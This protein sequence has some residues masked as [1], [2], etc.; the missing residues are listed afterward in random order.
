M[1]KKIEI[2]YVSSLCSTK[3]YYELF[4]ELKAKLGL[5][6]QKYHRLLAMG[7]VKNNIEVV[8]VSAIPIIRKLTDKLYYRKSSEVTDN[9]NYIYLPFVSL[10]ILRH[11]FL[12]ISCFITIVKI[13]HNNKNNVVILCDA[14]DISISMGGLLA[15]KIMH[16]RSICIVTDAPAFLVNNSK[17]K[18][19]LIKKIEFKLIAILNTLIINKFNAY[20]FLTNQMN[21]LINNREKPYIVLEG[22]VDI[23]MEDVINDI[24]KKYDK[25]ICMYAGS[26]KKVYGIKMLTEAFIKANVADSELHIYGSGNFEDELI[27]IC[28]KHSNIKFFGTFPNDYIVKEEMKATLLINPRPSNE[29]YTKYSF[30]SKNMEYMV[31]GTPLLTTKL[32]GMPAEYFDYIYLLEEETVDGLSAKL[33]Q[34]LNKPK[35]ELHQK[36]LKAKMFVLNYKNNVVQAKKIINMIKII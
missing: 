22:H 5:Q 24:N 32:F 27:K 31:S 36:G 7:F 26:L 4:D 15:G 28:E 11:L 25:K 16:K 10:P 18:I 19:T 33:I 34:L 13:C 6:I 21:K 17:Q 30:P 3:K 29:E 20:V 12:F 9:I 2:I 23:Q 8:A 14:L 35:E 1:N